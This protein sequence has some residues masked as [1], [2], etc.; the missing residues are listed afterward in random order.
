MNYRVVPTSSE[1]IIA[2]LM[3]RSH[4]PLIC[5]VCCAFATD[6][7]DLLIEHA[8]A[9]R[10]PSDVDRANAQI[11]LHTGSFWFCQLC[12]YKSPLK[13]NFQL[14]CKTEKHAQRMSL[15]LHINEGGSDNQKRLFFG[16]SLVTPPSPFLVKPAPPN[17]AIHLPQLVYPP[18]TRKP[19]PPILSHAAHSN[20]SAYPNAP[21]GTG[22]PVGLATNNCA[23]SPVGISLAS[24]IQLRCLPCNFFTTSVH[25]LRLHC[26][27]MEHRSLAELFV[28]VVRRRCQ[29]APSSLALLPPAVSASPDW[30]R[31]VWQA[32]MDEETPAQTVKLAAAFEAGLPTTAWPAVSLA[33]V[34]RVCCGAVGQG[35]R[36]F[37]RLVDLFVH[38]QSDE[39]QQVRS[40]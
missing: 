8:E 3:E 21:A 26:Q 18:G 22:L 38:L 27:T 7:V 23:S 12:A 35:N 5:Q 37:S 25:K 15:L 34:C 19:V 36:L 24:A 13:A 39:H 6:R 2:H 20:G 29:L 11:T 1:S 32:E 17:E 4:E 9:S 40:V 31:P 30:K 10:T 28:H 16:S 14:H 33:Y